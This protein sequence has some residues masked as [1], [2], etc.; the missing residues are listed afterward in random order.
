[1]NIR[2]APINLTKIAY[3][4]AS[5]RW[6]TI[7]WFCKVEIPPELQKTKLNYE[8][9]GAIFGCLPYINL[10]RCN[11][12]RKLGWGWQ[13][14]LYSNH[15]EMWIYGGQYL[16]IDFSDQLQEFQLYIAV[17]TVLCIL[18]VYFCRGYRFSDL[19]LW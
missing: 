10:H 3:M 5:K 17:S 13:M 2:Y 16:A 1:L 8:M 4:K 18:F 14:S 6:I 11:N 15:S 12:G 19:C 7:G 9:K